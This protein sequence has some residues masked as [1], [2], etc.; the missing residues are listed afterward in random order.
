[1]MN[2]DM[3]KMLKCILAGFL[4]FYIVPMAVVPFVSKE[5]FLVIWVGLFMA[6]NPI[7]MLVSSFWIGRWYAPVVSAVLFT[8]SMRQ[9][10]GIEIVWLYPV[11]YL[12]AGYVALGAM[13][14]MKRGKSKSGQKEDKKHER[15]K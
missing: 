12:A 11:L 15:K 5:N 14:V 10:Y 1:M 9:A 8:L 7:Y 2:D 4:V 3:K 6:V 13:W